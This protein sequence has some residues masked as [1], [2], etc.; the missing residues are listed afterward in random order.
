LKAYVAAAGQILAVDVRS[1]LGLEPERFGVDRIGPW[2]VSERRM[3]QLIED[4]RSQLRAHHSN[5]RLERGMTR[6]ALRASLGVDPEMFDGLLDRAD[7][8]DVDSDIV[9]MRTHGVDLSEEE[10]DRRGKLIELLRNAGYEPP[11]TKGLDTDPALLRA[12]SDE[13]TITRIGDFY[14]ATDVAEDAKRAIADL[15]R[16]QGS[17]TVAQVRDRLGTSRKYA[18]P[19]CEWLDAEGVTRRKGDQR[20]LGPHAPD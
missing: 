9:R 17:V 13:G 11:M 2:L 5:H 12:L 7:D 15:I 3:N 1:R 8:I 20:T 6:E 16:D 18:V 14:L 19:L 4:M 10:Q